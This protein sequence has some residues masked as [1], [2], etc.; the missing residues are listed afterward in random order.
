M[1][2]DKVRKEVEMRKLTKEEIQKFVSMPNVKKIAVEN[3]LM[4]LNL[5]G[6]FMDACM[7]LS[8]DAHLYKWNKETI[9]AIGKGIKLSSTLSY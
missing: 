1:T 3:F 5:N 9:N 2:E 8:Q 7:N 4:T 6:S